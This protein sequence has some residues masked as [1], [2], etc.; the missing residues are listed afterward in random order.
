MRLEE[1][2]PSLQ[3]TITNYK[4]YVRLQNC[5]L[6]L[7]FFLCSIVYVAPHKLSCRD[8]PEAG[9]LDVAFI[10]VFI[11]GFWDLFTFMIVSPGV[12]KISKFYSRVFLKLDP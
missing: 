4:L 3:H 1:R 8:S 2:S 5:T 11:L 7:P 12:P 10:L 9:S 6:R